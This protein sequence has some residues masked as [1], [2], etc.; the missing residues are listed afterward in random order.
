[1]SVHPAHRRPWT[2][3]AGGVVVCALLSACGPPTI[4]TGDLTDAEDR[5]C[6]D[7]VAALPA[8]LAGQD[9]VEVEGDTEHGAAWGDPP[10]VLTCGVDA[11]DISDAP[12]CTVVDGVGWVVP[13]EGGD[14]TVFT[15]D[16][17]RPR[18]QVVVPDDYAPEAEALV[19][20]AP[21]VERYTEV[22][23]RCL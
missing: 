19:A 11:L 7:L 14:E 9:S 22:E 20:L 6:R 18:V 12:P 23:D 8:S 4:E 5:A 15:A 16:G 21:L 2:L 13:D 3:V 17:Y 10:I 1:M